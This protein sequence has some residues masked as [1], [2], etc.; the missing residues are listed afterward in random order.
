[1]C[2]KLSNIQ[3]RQVYRPPAL[4]G[5]GEDVPAALGGLARL[6]A[7]PAAVRDL[8]EALDPPLLIEPP[9]HP[10]HDLV[11]LAATQTAGAVHHSSAA[12]AQAK[13]GL[14]QLLLPLRIR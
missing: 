3:H 11:I 8:H 5:V 14:E 13:P 12:A 10:L 7:Q 2:T 1:M 4:S 9:H 6:E